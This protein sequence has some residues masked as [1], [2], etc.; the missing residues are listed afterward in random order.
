MVDKDDWDRICSKIDMMERSF[1]ELKDDLRRLCG[2]AKASPETPT[3]P[4]S[5]GRVSDMSGPKY[6][7]AME[8]N[9]KSSL[10]GE[11]VHLGGGSVPALVAALNKG[12]GNELFGSSVLPLFG[13]DNESATYPFVSL[14]GHQGALP[15]VNELA[16]VLPGDA[17]CLESFRQY[18]DG[19]FVTYPAIVAAEKFESDLLLFLSNRRLAQT[20]ASHQN[21]GESMYGMPIR[22][23]GLLFAAFAAGIQFS[24]MPGKDRELLAQ[25]YSKLPSDS[26]RVPRL[27]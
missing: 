27:T 15:R 23:L 21:T 8:V 9:E 7:K 25:V 3:S 22:W 16:K 6:V 14:W 20:S 12:K 10:T 24:N 19:A 18:R 11:N 2:A 17:E 13:L 26:M 4:G 5:I 1:T